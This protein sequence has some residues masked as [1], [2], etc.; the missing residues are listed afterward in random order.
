MASDGSLIFDTKIDTSGFE[1]SS[2]EKAVDRLS[3]LV[4]S[5]SAKLDKTFS[6]SGTAVSATSRKVDG[7]AEAAKKAADEMERLRKE[8]ASVFSGTITNNNASV[9]ATPDNGKR[10]DIYGNDVDVMIAKNKELE[11]AARQASTAVT[12]ETQKEEKSVS[13]FKG[14][15]VFGG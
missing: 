6:D 9:L 14:Y 12:A 1:T 8:K 2:L 13:S 3:T 5:L 4:D 15:C 11:E 7:M 10:Y